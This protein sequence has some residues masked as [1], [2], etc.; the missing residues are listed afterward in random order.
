MIKI[1]T[2]WHSYGVNGITA[3]VTKTEPDGN[4]TRVYFKINT[5]PGEELNCWSGA[6]EQRYTMGPEEI[7]KGARQ[8]KNRNSIWSR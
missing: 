3:Q 7:N 8:E 4:E 6:F 1:G 5:R 2:I